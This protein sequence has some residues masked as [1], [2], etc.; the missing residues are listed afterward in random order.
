MPLNP[1]FQL[2]T[3]VW[4]VVFSPTPLKNDGVK[5]SWD[6]VFFPINGKIK[7]MFQSTNQIYLTAGS[8]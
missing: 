5:V 6:D 3:T 4:L 2:S 1:I 7:A 8:A